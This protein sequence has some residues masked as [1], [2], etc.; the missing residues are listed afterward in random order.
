MLT[1]LVVALLISFKKNHESTRLHTI[2]TGAPMTAFL[3]KT[4]YRSISRRTV[5]MTVVT[6]LFALGS[7]LFC[8]VLITYA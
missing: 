6:L 7:M 3:K 4:R 1:C 2:Q 8:F 5:E